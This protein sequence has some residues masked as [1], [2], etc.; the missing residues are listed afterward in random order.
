MPEPMIASTLRLAPFSLQ[1]ANRAAISDAISAAAL[2]QPVTVEPAPVATPV[3]KLRPELLAQMVA[4][5]QLTV[6]EPVAETPGYDRS[7]ATKPILDAPIP[8]DTSLFTSPDGSIT[9]YLPRYRLKEVSNGR[10]D[11]AL[12]E[13]EGGGFRLAIG[14]E[15]FPPPEVAVPPGAQ[16]LPHTTVALVS[17]TNSQGMPEELLLGE[18][19]PDANGGLVGGAARLSTELRESLIYSIGQ[20]GQARL[21]VRRGIEVAAQIVP[22]GNSGPAPKFMLARTMRHRMRIKRS[23]M[24]IAR[25][26]QDTGEE[27]LDEPAVEE[28]TET[29]P[30]PSP[31]VLRYQDVRLVL[32]Q[33]AA[34]N[35]LFLSET[36]HPYF[37]ANGPAVAVRVAQK[38]IAIPFVDKSGSERHFAY[39]QN[40]QDASIF[41]Y[42]PDSYRLARRKEEPFAPEMRVRMSTP[43]G[44][45]EKATAIIDYVVRPHISPDRLEAALARLASELPPTMIAEGKQP[46]LQPLAAFPKYR[47]RIPGAAGVEMKE[48]EGVSI[49]LANGFKHTL[50]ASL[51][52]FQQLFASAF[53]NDATSL[54]TGEVLVET[55]GASPES[56]PVDIRFAHTEGPLIDTV[57]TTTADGRVEVKMRN[58]TESVLSIK[59]LPVSIM[60]ADQI[61]AANTERL[62]L[63]QPLTLG[64]GQ[65]ISFAV[66]PADSLAGDQPLDAIFDLSGIDVVPDAGTMLATI[67]DRSVPAEYEREIEIMTL[68]DLLNG[69]PDNPIVL[70]SVEFKTGNTVKLTQDQQNVVASVKMPLVNILMGEDS[71]GAYQYRQ[72]IVH[73]SGEQVTDGEWR[74]SDHDLLIVP[75][76]S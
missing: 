60:R 17:F 63:T 67:R 38:R 18:Q 56:V 28:A 11:I 31:P 42:L 55:G 57:E 5:P 22:S 41:F 32:E 30:P 3:F 33:V 25:H 52:E 23:P 43:D 54:F 50:A 12:T 26:F 19:I 7:A 47:M 15:R 74:H 49:D 53:S 68:P 9:Y 36:L 62:D 76:K 29:A 73:R 27:L 59:N 72:L 70:I 8:L 16:E 75:V 39:F 34:P 13:A 10:Y 1:V 14:L 44:T 66:S 69:T 64:S 58:G 71:K 40:S 4:L 20:L 24:E 37:Y 2:A 46:K 6:L 45:L 35:P 61:F 21:V 51:P 48:Y 65:S